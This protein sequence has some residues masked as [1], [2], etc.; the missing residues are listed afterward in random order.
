MDCPT[1]SS[2]ISPASTLPGARQDHSKIAIA[3]NQIAQSDSPDTL[4]FP[5]Q[6]L[7]P[8]KTV[9]GEFTH[10]QIYKNTPEFLIDD[11][12]VLQVELSHARREILHLQRELAQIQSELDQAHQI[13]EQIEK[14][15]IA[16]PIVRIRQ[17]MLDLMA[18]IRKRKNELDSS[19]PVIVTKSA[20]SQAESPIK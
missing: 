18:A 10:S 8:P 17:K 15:P 9:A 6:I 20:E 12:T 2:I 4:S 16:G 19:C 13:F 7:A 5:A 14:H 1:P 3:S 11:K